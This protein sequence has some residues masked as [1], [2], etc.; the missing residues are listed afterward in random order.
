MMNEKEKMLRGEPY[1]A[2]D[3]ELAELRALAHRLSQDYNATYDT[4]IEKRAAILDKL[5]P[6]HG[7][8]WE[9]RVR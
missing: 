2:A 5:L 8:N 7:N 1:N 4:E 3:K 9:W 6:D